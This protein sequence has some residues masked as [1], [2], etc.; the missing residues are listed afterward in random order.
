MRRKERKGRG[1]YRR[2]STV[3]GEESGMWGM[4]FGGE[5]GGGGKV[6]FSG[7]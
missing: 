3:W 6:V 1:G 4:E 2:R 5:W 7:F